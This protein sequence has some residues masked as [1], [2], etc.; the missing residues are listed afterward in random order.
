MTMATEGRWAAA[1]LLLE[2]AACLPDAA[3]DL[4]AAA[5][6]CD[7][8]RRRA[9]EAAD[10]LTGVPDPERRR[11]AATRIRGAGEIDLRVAERLDAALRCG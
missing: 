6:L 10:A 8:V 1:R 11:A 7:E 4:E 9:G 2:A 5:S 3:T